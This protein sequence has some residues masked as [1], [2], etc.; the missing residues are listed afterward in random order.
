[1]RFKRILTATILLNYVYWW[2]TVAVGVG[3]TRR[4]KL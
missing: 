3:H 1:M 4:D 2:R